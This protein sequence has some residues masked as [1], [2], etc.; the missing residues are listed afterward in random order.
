MTESAINWKELL[1]RLKME[2][3][4]EAAPGFFELSGGYRMKVKPYT[5]K[6]A[7]G[8]TAA[9]E[10]FINYLPGGCGE[11][12]RTN[13]MG[14]PRV[15]NGEVRWTK[16]N[17]RKGVADIRG[18]YNG[19]AL[20]I[21]VKIGRDEQSEAQIKEMHRIRKAGGIYWVAKTFPDFLEQ[22]IAAGFEVPAFDPQQQST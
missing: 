12:T 2:H 22:W 5:D 1:K 4:K 10:D 21:E 11:A 14:T 16:S 9:I 20:N 13:T 19:K 6:T 18:T 3:I 8:L 7:N 17:T 15:V